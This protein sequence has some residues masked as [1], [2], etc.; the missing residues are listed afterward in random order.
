MKI[1]ETKQEGLAYGFEITIPANDID[2]RVEDK[3]KEYGKTIRI[4]GFRPGKVP[5]NILK[6][7]YGKAIM[8]E[9]LELAVNETSAKIMAD[10]S[11]KPAMQPKIEVKS[12]DADQ[13]LVYTMDLEVLPEIKLADFKGIKLEKPIAEVTEE[14]IEESL[15]KIAEGNIST[16]PITGKR[17]AKDGDTLKMDF[18]GRTAD[19]DVHHDGMKAE[20]HMLKLGSGA[21]IPGFEE[22]LVGVKAGESVDVNV[23]FPDEYGAEHLAGRDA[24]FAVTVHEIH[25]D[26]EGAID[27]AL[28]E[29]LGMKDLEAL[30]EAVK[31]QMQME[32][33]G[34]SK[35]VVK[36]YL[37]DELDALHQ[38]LEI[39]PGLL[40][41]EY[42]NIMDQVKLDRQQRDGEDAGELELSKDEEEEFKYI[43]ERRVRLGLILAEIGNQNGITVADADLQRAVVAEAQKYPGQEKQVFD[44]FSQN[45]QALEQLRGP[46]F[47]EKTVDFILEL[48]EITDKTVTLDELANA[49][50]EDSEAET[51]SKKKAATKKKP[52]SA[53]ASDDKP[54]AKKKA[55]AKKAADDKPAAKKKAPA[56]KSSA[57]KKDA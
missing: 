48:A 54:A 57:K 46:M 15:A 42:T 26:A 7:R 33:D 10:K 55:P 12:F 11:L 23:K 32:Y 44:Y 13:D 4:Q 5:M 20:G 2:A 38:D 53:K 3:L 31:T 25:E 6:S 49:L 21:F 19:D 29:R 28:A 39:P 14:S 43:A 36:K 9:V 27:D 34:Q 17:A 18:D 30:K 22:Q 52:S 24:I 8:G 50:D 40:D 16:Q 35:T 41:S 56:K 51:K 1:K 47:E 45:K 37:L